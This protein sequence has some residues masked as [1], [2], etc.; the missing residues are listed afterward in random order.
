MRLSRVMKAKI[1]CAV[2][3]CVVFLFAGLFW[4]FRVYTKT[5]EYALRAIQSALDQHDEAVF[6]RYVRLDTVLD[7]GYDDFMAGTMDAEF[8]HSYEAS[9]ALEDFSKSLHLSECL[10]MQYIHVWQQGNGHP[11]T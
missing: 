5:P 6:L 4:Y 11:L 3:L 9:T 2:L 1:A 7:T 8:S 10:Q